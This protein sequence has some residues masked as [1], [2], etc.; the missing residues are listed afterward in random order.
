MALGLHVSLP[1]PVNSLRFVRRVVAIEGDQNE[2][3]KHGGTAP[4]RESRF[5]R[6][7]LGAL[8]MVTI[9]AASMICGC[10]Q[11]RA[12]DF[13]RSSYSRPARWRRSHTPYEPLPSTRI[14]KASWY[15]PGFSGRR[16][17]SGER[18]DPNQMTAAS[19]TLPIGSVVHVTNLANGRSVT[20]RIN[21]RGPY[22]RG[23]SLDLSRGAASRIGLMRKG[24]AR[25]KVTPVPAHSATVTAAM[26]E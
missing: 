7:A 26:L 5:A 1:V 18:F 4:E 8:A 15:G 3:F 25:V 16:T 21:D 10:G 2:R 11:I 24:V 12:P 23:R 6:A 20:V 17:A 22:V 9:I 14:V 19:K 13:L